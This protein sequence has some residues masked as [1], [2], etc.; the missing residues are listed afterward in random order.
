MRKPSRVVLSAATVLALTAVAVPAT[1]TP[2]VVLDQ[3]HV[4]VVGIAWEDN[5]FN[6]GPR[7]DLNAETMVADGNSYK[8]AIA[9]G[10]KLTAHGL[11]LV[12]RKNTDDETS[13]QVG[14]ATANHFWNQ[15]DTRTEGREFHY[16]TTPASTSTS[17]SSTS[18]STSTS[19]TSSRP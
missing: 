1:A 2:S 5:A 16:T 4:D 10:L 9:A 3:G 15:D 19:S 11:A 17:S 12:N 14:D 18:S 13:E 7:S 8:K 6:S